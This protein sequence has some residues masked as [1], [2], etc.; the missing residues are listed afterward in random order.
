MDAP[1]TA[2]TPGAE[3]SLVNGYTSPKLEV[4]LKC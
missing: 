4:T 2:L 3:S 1:Y